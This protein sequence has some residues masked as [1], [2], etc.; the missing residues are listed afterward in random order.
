MSG[1]GY[2]V[3]YIFLRMIGDD[4]TE[5]GDICFLGVLPPPSPSIFILDITNFVP[6]LILFADTGTGHQWQ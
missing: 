6:M 5:I 4:E 3:S 1:C 2:K